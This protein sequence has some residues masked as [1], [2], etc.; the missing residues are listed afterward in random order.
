MAGGLVQ[1][2]TYGNQ[3]LMLTG[4]PEITFFN[5]IYRRYTN[6]G[7]RI[8]ELPFDNQVVFG[9]TSV[10]TIPKNS[11]DLISR[12]TLKIK[13]PKI[14]INGLNKYI[15]DNNNNK[16]EYTSVY[17]LYYDFFIEFYNTL[18]NVVNI[19]FNKYDK[20]EKNLTYINDL[21]TYIM[22]NINNDKYEQFFRC[23]N[24]FF[25]DGLITEKNSVNTKIYTNASLFQNVND[26][27]I[28]IYNNWSENEM[29]YDL[30][31]FTIYKNMGILKDLNVVLYNKLKEIVKNDNKIKISWVDKI[32]I[33][34]FNSIDFYIGSNKINSLS[35]IYINNYGNLFYQNPEVYNKI[36]GSGQEL[37]LFTIQKDEYELF[38][39]IPFW[40]NGNYGLSFPLLALQFNSVQIKINLK[41]FVECIKIDINSNYNSEKIQNDILNY[42]INEEL[43]IIKSSLEVSMLAE[44]IYLDG[45][46]R[47]KFAQSAHEYL[48]TQVQEIDFDN[49]GEFNNAFTL[50]FFHCCK[51]MY[52][53]AIKER[54]LRDVFNKKSSFLYCLEKDVLELTKHQKDYVEYFRILNDYS[55]SYN[56]NDFISGLS[57]YNNNISNQDYFTFRAQNMINDLD[58]LVQNYDIIDASTLYLNSTVLIGEDS[59]YFNY[60]TPYKSYNSTPQ[61]GLYSYSFSLYPTETQ[62]SGSINLSRIPSFIL[63]I[64]ISELLSKNS[65]DK[66]QY[67][68]SND[69]SSIKYLN[70]LG[71]KYKLVIE[72]TNFNVLRLIGGIG[73]VAYTY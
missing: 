29:S 19:F 6:F 8:T 26:N 70:T 35:D 73:A 61:K 58:D 69:F 68:N 72:T 9:G 28:Y 42:L 18:Q 48:I 22:E 51:D 66:I 59:T 52:W 63:R 50:N 33:Y 1:V 49:I 25:N 32:G 37:N 17:V 30:F 13:L 71:E 10:L 53:C 23:V 54:N 41:K 44:Y 43:Q 21:S 67:Q 3:D 12:L 4:N 55:K 62:P 36:I 11:G 40:F 20:L 46:E 65:K 60:V 5:I 2:I 47:K 64:K 16:L 27:L 7:K 39:P 34:L 57:V 56:P 38:L 15:I 14:D 24:Y 45:I 31:K